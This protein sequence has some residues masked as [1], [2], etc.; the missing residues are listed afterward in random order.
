MASLNSLL[1]VMCS[2]IPAISIFLLSVCFSCFDSTSSRGDDPSFATVVYYIL[3]YMRPL[4]LFREKRGYINEGE[5]KRPLL[6]SDLEYWYLKYFWI[7]GIRWT[8]TNR[9][10]K[11]ATSKPRKRQFLPLPESAGRKRTKA[12]MLPANFQEWPPLPSAVSDNSN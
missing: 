5:S 11:A 10:E 2:G 8:S 9:T 4:S 1:P 7:W 6:W 12:S 3:I